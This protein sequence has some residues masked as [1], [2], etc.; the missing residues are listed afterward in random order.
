MPDLYTPQGL[1]YNPAEGEVVR[2]EHLESGRPVLILELRNKHQVRAI[3]NNDDIHSDSLPSI[4]ARVECVQTQG[5][6]TYVRTIDVLQGR[7]VVG[8]AG[9]GLTVTSERAHVYSTV[10]RWLGMNA[11]EVLLNGPA[12]QIRM[13]NH[14]LEL[15][16]PSIGL[17]LGTGA[18]V[19]GGRMNM[20]S[21][22]V[23]LPSVG[24]S[25]A[26]YNIDSEDARPAQT[27]TAAQHS[28][29]MS[30]V[31]L[32]DYRP[33]FRLAQR[34]RMDDAAVDTDSPIGIDAQP[35]AKAI[36][37]HHAANQRTYSWASLHRC[38]LVQLGL[39]VPRDQRYGWD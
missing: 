23:Y 15:T 36:M 18:R 5:L 27:Q 19:T 26:L 37:D 2:V 35:I 31:H 21:T 39:A 17:E 25:N 16:G 7:A 4:G 3:L 12:N 1:E 9:A 11:E 8:V 13:A 30:H 38:A 28:H 6:W 29:S 32:V 20:P 24:R 22:D 34:F 14:A 10:N 33:Q